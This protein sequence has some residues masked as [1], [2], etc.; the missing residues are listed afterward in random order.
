VPEAFVGDAIVTT[1]VPLPAPSTRGRCRGPSWCRARPGPARAGS[2]RAGPAATPADPSPGGAAR[3]CSCAVPP[4]CRDDRD[5]RQRPG[6]DRP[7][8]RRARLPG[9]RPPAA[10]LGARPHPQRARPRPDHADATRG[11]PDAAPAGS[12]MCCCPPWSPTT[13]EARTTRSRSGS[14]HG[15][16]CG[17]PA[18]R[19]RGARSVR[20]CR[21]QPGGVEP[22]GVDDEPDPVG[23]EVLERRVEVL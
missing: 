17:R 1:N 3:P 10:T 2:R 6:R 13:N 19:N 15:R 7:R 14:P 23:D 16:R 11:G 21:G 18:G 20:G 12:P 5:R 22:A 9:M 8:R 4:P